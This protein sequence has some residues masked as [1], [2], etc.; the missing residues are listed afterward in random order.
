M[1]LEG[2]EFHRR[3][4]L[5]RRSWRFVNCTQAERLCPRPVASRPARSRP[6][7]V[8]PATNSTT[9]QRAA[10]PGLDPWIWTM[11]GCVTVAMAQASGV[12]PPPAAEGARRQD[13]DRHVAQRPVNRVIQ[14]SGL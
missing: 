6:A 9:R 7:S 8:P 5:P 3:R 2:P 4:Q 14:V 1:V 11:A 10:P 13:L 12:G